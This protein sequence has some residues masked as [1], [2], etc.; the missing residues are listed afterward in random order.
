MIDIDIRFIGEQMRQ[1]QA[2]IRAIKQENAQHAVALRLLQGTMTAQITQTASEI[3]SL[4]S[5]IEEQFRAIETR[6]DAIDARFAEVNRQ[7]AVN[8]EVLLAAI[9]QRG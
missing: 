4:R 5:E 8:L 6:L 9:G 3:G 7:M 2:D 1:M